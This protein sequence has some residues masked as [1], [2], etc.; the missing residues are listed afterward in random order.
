MDR[1]F[2][3]IIYG[4]IFIG[5]VFGAVFGAKFI[6]GLQIIPAPIEVIE[7]SKNIQIVEWLEAESSKN[8][9]LSDYIIRLYNPDDKQGAEKI[10]YSIGE[11]SGATYLLPLEK[12]IIVISGERRNLKEKD[13]SVNIVK[14]KDFSKENDAELDISEKKYL[15]EDSELGG[16]SVSASIFNKS[17]YDFSVVDIDVILYNLQKQPVAV[18]SSKI[19]TLLSGQEQ[20][21]KVFWP[22]II[23]DDVA[24]IFIQVSSNIIDNDNAKIN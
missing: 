1:I 13:F 5:A 21:F 17:K 8:S 16:S 4:A 19:N 22:Y 9:L 20:S 10:E 6:Q 23:K 15:S 2:K 24:E 12:K 11:F 7:N 18:V 14:M 3:Q